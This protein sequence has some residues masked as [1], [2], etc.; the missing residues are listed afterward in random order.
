M[1]NWLAD[2]SKPDYKC[3]VQGKLTLHLSNAWPRVKRHKCH[4]MQCDLETPQI[5]SYHYHGSRKHI[6]M[7]EDSQGLLQ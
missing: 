5:M 7:Y 6:Y 3:E 4:M 2:F 1:I